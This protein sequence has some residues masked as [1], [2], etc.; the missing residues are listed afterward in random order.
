MNKN[1]HKHTKIQRLTPLVLMRRKVPVTSTM[2]TNLTCK[3]SSVCVCFGQKALKLSE[4]CRMKCLPKHNTCMG[5]YTQHQMS[6]PKDSTDGPKDHLSIIWHSKDQHGLERLS[7][8]FII[9]TISFDEVEG[10]ISS[11]DLLSFDT[12][13]LSTFLTTVD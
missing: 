12:V 10:S 13:H 8:K 9:R 4:V 6:C 1:K 5:I 3:L 11:F 2:F 7:F